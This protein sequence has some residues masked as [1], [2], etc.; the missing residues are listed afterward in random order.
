M[1][2][3][4]LAAL[5]LEPARH[6]EQR[7]FHVDESDED[8]GAIK[9]KKER[10]NFRKQRLAAAAAQYS[11][12]R[13]PNLIP[14]K[15]TGPDPALTKQLDEIAGRLGKGYGKDL[16]ERRWCFRDANGVVLMTTF[17][18]G[19]VNP[20]PNGIT[21]TSGQSS[22]SELG[23][24][25]IPGADSP[26]GRASVE[27]GGQQGGNAARAAARAAGIQLPTGSK[28]HYPTGLLE[29]S[30]V[31]RAIVDLL[32]DLSD[33]Q[34]IAVA[35]VDV[36]GA[37]DGDPNQSATVLLPVVEHMIRY[38]RATTFTRDL[39]PAWRDRPEL[40]WNSMTLNEQLDNA[41]M[42]WPLRDRQLMVQ[43]EEGHAHQAFFDRDVTRDPQPHF[44]PL[45]LTAPP[46]Q[47]KSALALLMVS[48]AVN[49]GYTVLFS[50]APHKHAVLREMLD[51]IKENLKWDHYGLQVANMSEPGFDMATVPDRD[52]L[53]YS[54]DVLTDVLLAS[55]A[56]S[57]LITAG[58]PCFHIHDEGQTMAKKQQRAPAQMDNYGPEMPVEGPTIPGEGPPVLRRAGSD[59]QDSREEEYSREPALILREVRRNYSNRRGLICLVSATVLPTYMEPLWGDIGTTLQQGVNNDAYVWR[60]HLL[61]SNLTPLRPVGFSLMA[62]D[63]VAP[64][65][66]TGYSGVERLRMNGTI[67]FGEKYCFDKPGRSRAPDED[68]QAI[69]RHFNTFLAMQPTANQGDRMEFLQPM[70]VANLTREMQ[71]GKGGTMDWINNLYI[72]LMQAT[73]RNGAVIL[74]ASGTGARVTTMLGVP[75]S[76]DPAR[77]LADVPFSPAARSNAPSL[78]PA[79]QKDPDYFFNDEPLAVVPFTPRE[80]LPV[81]SAPNCST[82]IAMA[83]AAMVEHA[84]RPLPPGAMPESPELEKFCVLGYAMM[85][86]AVTLQTYTVDPDTGRETMYSVGSVCTA[87]S[88]DTPLDELFQMIGRGFADFR[89]ASYPNFMIDLLAPPHT[90]TKLRGMAEIEGRVAMPLDDE[91]LQTARMLRMEPHRNVAPQLV[92]PLRRGTDPANR[93]YA[94]LCEWAAVRLLPR[95][96]SHPV[97]SVRHG[98]TPLRAKPGGPVHYLHAEEYQD[99][100][101][102]VEAP[103]YFLPNT[104]LIPPT[105]PQQQIEM[106]DLPMLSTRDRLA[107]VAERLRRQEMYEFVPALQAF[108]RYQVP[109]REAGGFRDAF[110]ADVAGDFRLGKRRVRL[111]E[112]LPRRT[113]RDTNIDPAERAARLHALC[114][115]VRQRVNLN[116]GQRTRWESVCTWPGFLWEMMPIGSNDEEER[117]FKVD[118]ALPYARYLIPDDTDDVTVTKRR[119]VLYRSV[120]AVMRAILQAVGSELRPTQFDL[121]HT[122]AAT[123]ARIAAARP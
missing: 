120:Q 35:S 71:A 55:Q 122:D 15:G 87:Y 28:L 6:Q 70:Y 101:P 47:G 67:T 105:P 27:V 85:E 5:S 121:Y 109:D 86:A 108:Q 66:A 59:V 16:F 22:T 91:D 12:S 74:F 56:V 68:I 25:G 49:L 62:H 64:A 45:V 79:A 23:R 3:P 78:T 41:K 106:D 19:Q 20:A 72:P 81:M 38:A 82:A 26:G 100:P 50:V 2:L 31:R 29:E 34:V 103:F 102:T 65:A 88:E 32:T 112:V 53:L 93:D 60:T 111:S 33:Y 114:E 116:P 7:E 36:A 115:V 95:D 21:A 117:V 44:C 13:P 69:A 77:P 46:R 73:G 17:V 118:C 54:S 89:S 76:V 123:L 52:L 37:V 9:K 40:H 98:G 39:P 119:A 48:I 92:L 94:S 84:K 1:E 99:K 30:T 24:V 4:N 90:A 58:K 97:F 10:A 63:T 113:L 11:F 80:V 57:A 61:P 51:K 107:I 18:Q 104:R 83:K 8:T 75:P 14:Y 43:L 96:R 42:F 110:L